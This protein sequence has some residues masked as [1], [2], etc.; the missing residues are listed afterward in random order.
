MKSCLRN[1][2]L[3]IVLIIAFLG[4]LMGMWISGWQQENSELVMHGMPPITLFAYLS[5][6]SF[7]SALFENW[8]SEWLQMSFYVMLTAVLFQK[9][10]AE[11]R[12]PDKA[13]VEKDETDASKKHYPAWMR[14]SSLARWLYRYSL[15]LTLAL[16]FVLSFAGHLIASC[17]SHN[18]QAAIHHE[19]SRSILQ[20]FVSSQFWF[21]SFQ[22]WQSE[23]FS[24]AT[25]VIFSIFL[26]F[27]GSPESKPV[28]ASNSET[29]A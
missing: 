19:V 9:G 14:D 21:E 7:L 13:K 22:N 20:H 6:E 8:E 5:D 16:L 28:S 18:S 4:S 1:N 12:D 3:T 10:S 11:S 15:G 29:G 25:L 26:R 27:K 17:T 2:G 23:F 24:T